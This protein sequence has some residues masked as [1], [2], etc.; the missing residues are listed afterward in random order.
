MDGGMKGLSKE[1]AEDA[2]AVQALFVFR[3]PFEQTSERTGPVR[4][5]ALLIHVDK[6]IFHVPLHAIDVF[7]PL[8]QA[9]HLWRYVEVLTALDL[10]DADSFVSQ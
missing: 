8:P 1:S 6:V 9:L 2:F 10:D 5:E 3:K 7:T 4:V